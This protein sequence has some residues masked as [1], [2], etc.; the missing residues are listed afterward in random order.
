MRTVNDH[1]S[2]VTVSDEALRFD[3]GLVFLHNDFSACYDCRFI[4]PAVVVVVSMQQPTKE[5]LM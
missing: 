5:D 4:S 2:A 1:K 3:K